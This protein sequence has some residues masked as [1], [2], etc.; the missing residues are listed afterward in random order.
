MSSSLRIFVTDRDPDYL[1]IEILATSG[2]F[3]GAAHVYAD[4]DELTRFGKLLSGFPSGQGDERRYEF[5]TK[6]A[7]IAGGYCA[8]RFYCKDSAGHAVLDVEFEDDDQ[9]YSEASATFTMSPVCAAGMDRFI[10]QIES[11]RRAGS[12]EAKLEI[13]E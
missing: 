9:I 7:G 8:L 6:D 3:S 13:P 4:L 11:I 12:R 1:D 10:A 2:R 5:G